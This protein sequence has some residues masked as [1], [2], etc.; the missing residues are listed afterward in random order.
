MTV[1]SSSYDTIMACDGNVASKQQ[2]QQ[3]HVFPMDSPGTTSATDSVSSFDEDF[4]PRALPERLG[5]VISSSSL[6]EDSDDENILQKIALPP[7]RPMVRKTISAGSAQY[8]QWLLAER[9]KLEQDRETASTLHELKQ[10]VRL[11]TMDSTDYHRQL[12]DNALPSLSSKSENHSISLSPSSSMIQNQMM[13][14]SMAIHRL[15]SVVANLTQ[16][17]DSHTDDTQLLQSQLLACQERAQ[18]VEAAAHRLY[19]RNQKLKRQTQH[20]SK[21]LQKLQ[22]KLRQYEKQLEAQEMQLVTSQLHHHELQ[23]Q[24]QQRGC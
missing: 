9:L 10:L 7:R 16:D 17:V 2:Q 8:D 20:D 5:R 3:Q 19:R 4:T 14:L 15:H 13:Q 22:S 1:P 23:L 11:A 21:A 18:Q 24:L 12:L 6:S